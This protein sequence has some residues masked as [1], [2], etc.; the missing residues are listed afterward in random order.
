MRITDYLRSLK[1]DPFVVTLAL[2]TGLLLI[3]AC[4]SLRVIIVLDNRNET[5]NQ[6]F[7]KDLAYVSQEISQRI[8]SQ[9]NQ[10]Q[11]IAEQQN[12]AQHLKDLD[13]SVLNNDETLAISMID[14]AEAIFYIDENLVRHQKTLSSAVL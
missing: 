8:E 12:V 5:I 7:G 10:L 6:E 11:A 1:S 14:V 4:I 13:I 9:I 2:V 3:W